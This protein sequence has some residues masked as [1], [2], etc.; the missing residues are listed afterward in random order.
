MQFRT[1][2]KETLGLNMKKWK[3]LGAIIIKKLGIKKIR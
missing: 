3:I 1:T 2:G